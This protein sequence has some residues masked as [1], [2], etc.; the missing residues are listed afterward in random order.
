MTRP[1][2]SWLM[3]GRPIADVRAWL[4]NTLLTPEIRRQYEAA[5]QRV[6][7]EVKARF[8]EIIARDED[9]WL[10]DFDTYTGELDAVA[11][12]LDALRE[13]AIDGGISAD[14]YD[15]ELV[16]LDSARQ[17]LVARAEEPERVS[18]R[19]ESD[20]ADPL[21]TYDELLAKFPAL[22]RPDFSFIPIKGL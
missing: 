15:A 9:Q 1:I 17:R 18:N 16:R 4:D 5:F 22:P 11:D 13:R 14:E 8:A 7:D 10:L 21:G 3:T 19:I 12:E 20:T 6:A 2:D